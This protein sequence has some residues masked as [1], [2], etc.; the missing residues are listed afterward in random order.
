MTAKQL[1]DQ[2]IRAD[3]LAKSIMDAYASNALMEYAR[4]CREQAELIAI[5]SSYHQTPTS[6]INLS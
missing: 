2:A 4:E 6:Q 1:L 5:A 3:R